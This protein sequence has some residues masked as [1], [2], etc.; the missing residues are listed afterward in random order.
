MN[1]H[2]SVYNLHYLGIS[3]CHSLHQNQITI[4]IKSFTLM[5]LLWKLMFFTKSWQQATY[6]H[7]HTLF[8]KGWR[9]TV[10]IWL[11]YFCV[12][13]R[14]PQLSE[15]SSKFFKLSITAEVTHNKYGFRNLLKKSEQCSLKIPGRSTKIIGIKWCFMTW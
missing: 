13:R 6:V 2:K 15:E 12:C 4:L 10:S 9:G 5:H 11:P 1:L 7:S 8:A 14:L 3:F